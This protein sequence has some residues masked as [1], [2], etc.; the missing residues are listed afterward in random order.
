MKENS[1]FL[2]KCE[3]LLLK[4][5]PGKTSGHL[6]RTYLVYFF[7]AILMIITKVVIAR[8]YGQTELGIYSYFFAI[9]S[10]LFIWT[11]FEF[12]EALTQLIVKG[13]YSLKQVFW[14]SNKWI[15][16]TTFLMLLGLYLIDSFF[17]TL[18]ASYSYLFLALIVFVISYTIY[19]QL[20]SVLRGDKQFAKSSAFSLVWRTSF[21]VGIVILAFFNISFYLVL[22]L[23]SACILFAAFTMLPDFLKIWKKTAHVTQEF[24]SS[25]KLWE[26]AFALFLVQVGFYSLRTVDLYLLERLLSFSDVGFY[27]AYASFTNVIRLLAYVFPVVVLPMAAVSTFKIRKSLFRLVA[28]LIPFAA[29]VL[30]FTTLLTPWLYG[31][32]Y[33]GGFWLAL[34]LVVSA[35]ILLIFAYCSSIFVGENEVGSSYFW[36]LGFDFILSLV[37]NAV[38]N[39]YFILR[40]G[41]IG[42][43]IATGIVVFVKVLFIL[44]AIKW[45]RNIKKEKLKLEQK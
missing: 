10:F 40:F 32:E 29:V 4:L 35:S 19:Y 39:Y 13:K 12:P 14:L 38:L 16:F 5:V 23:I 24:V 17:Y 42:S 26:L 18:F 9:A 20:Y 8:F 31:A 36:V 45:F 41:L 44:F 22:L 1:T 33:A 6:L 34:W 30:L 21:I 25:T 11:S 7:V 28:L 43:P 3:A 15:L 2:Q 37:G 27:S